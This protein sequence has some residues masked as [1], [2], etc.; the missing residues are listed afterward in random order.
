MGGNW[1]KLSAGK[2]Y[3]INMDLVT[4]VQLGNLTN[5]KGVVYF[6]S[7]MGGHPKT[8]FLQSDEDVILV[9]EWVEQ[10]CFKSQA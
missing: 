1:I 8:I 10:N 9:K 7:P 5:G 6:T 3:A 2:I 4:D